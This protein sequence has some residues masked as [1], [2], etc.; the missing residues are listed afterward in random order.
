MNNDR[1]DRRNRVLPILGWAG[2]IVFL[3]FIGFYLSVYFQ[4]TEG[5][6]DNPDSAI[7]RDFVVFWSSAVLIADG[8]AG[9]LYQPEAFRASLERLFAFDAPD[10]T[11]T[12]PPHMLFV[13]L[14]LAAFPY[15]WA[16]AAWSL[17][18]LAAYLAVVRRAALLGAPATF[19]NLYI[20]QTGLLIGAAYFGALALL[21]R[22]PVLAGVCIGLIS[23]KPH[24]GVLIPVALLAG[25]AW[26]TFASATLTVLGAVLLSALVFGW[27]AWRAWL[28]DALPHQASLMVGFDGPIMVS[29]FSGARIAGWPAWG[30]WLVQTPFTLVAVFATWWV[31]SRRRHGLV[32]DTSAMNVILL[33]TAIA[34]PY[35][36]VYDLPLITPVVLSAL[37]A[38]RRR[39]EKLRDLGELALWLVI[40]MLP[41]LWIAIGSGMAPVGSLAL[42]AALLLTLWRAAGED[43]TGQTDRTPPCI[44]SGCKNAT[45][46]SNAP[47]RA[48]DR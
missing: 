7:G 28:F 12:H 3:A 1:D 14:P 9:E 42:L 18:G 30:A 22:H 17:A 31:F 40:W 37:A 41:V 43:G 5:V 10:Y 24:L 33:A 21:R 39:A 16:L 44:G 48:R 6:L 38:W 15:L 34:T 32:S 36:F 35:L 45:A 29:A 47:A 46:F 8:Q 2:N 4:N 23:V 27:E 25:R 20:G 19:I 26:R 11:F 13:V